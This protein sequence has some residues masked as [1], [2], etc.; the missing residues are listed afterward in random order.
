M[1][2][3]IF[4]NQRCRNVL[5]C[6]FPYHCWSVLFSPIPRLVLLREEECLSSTE[7]SMDNF[8]CVCCPCTPLCFN[9]PPLAWLCPIDPVAQLH[10]EWL[11]LN[12]GE[13]SRSFTS[14]LRPSV[15]LFFFESAALHPWQHKARVSER[16]KQD[17]SFGCKAF[18]IALVASVYMIF[19]TCE[20]RACD[21]S[22]FLYL[23]YLF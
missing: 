10:P 5:H 23:D 15:F 21:S 2:I 4:F 20:A 19:A 1:I 14:E 3:I 18:A 7:F 11:G 6:I 16:R 9:S 12:N 22:F 17:V 13:H 8:Y